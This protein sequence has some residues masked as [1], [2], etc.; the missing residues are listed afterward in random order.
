MRND[1]PRLWRCARFSVISEPEGKP[2]FGF[3]TTS[4]GRCL[5]ERAHQRFFQQGVIKKILG[6]STGLMKRPLSQ[7]P[8]S[9]SLQCERDPAIIISVISST[10]T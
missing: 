10:P 9:Q 6:Q 2:E 3:E 7:R 5:V 4:G 1:L 8:L